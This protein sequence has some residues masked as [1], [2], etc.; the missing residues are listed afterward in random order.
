MKKTGS[1]KKFLGILLAAYV[2]GMV[3][4]AGG[5]IL[6]QVQRTDAEAVEVEEKKKIALTFD[7]GPNPYFTM[8]LLEGLKN[9]G[10]RPRFLCLVRR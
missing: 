4:A 3:F 6:H 1:G 10:E 7:D 5:Q 2:A 9:R 8:E